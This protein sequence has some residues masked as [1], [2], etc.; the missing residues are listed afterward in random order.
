MSYHQRGTIHRTHAISDQKGIEHSH[1]DY[2]TSFC[3]TTIKLDC[4][5]Y[6]LLKNK[7]KQKS[8]PV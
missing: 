8:K 1:N 7:L 3:V 5:N 2:I 4:S 6:Y